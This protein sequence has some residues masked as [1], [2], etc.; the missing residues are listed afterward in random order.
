VALVHTVVL[1]L[2][3]YLLAW[4]LDWTRWWVS[5]IGGFVVGGLPYAVLALPW[6]AQP[7]PDL[8]AA[9]VIA[10]FSWLF[11][12]GVALGLGVLGMAGGFAAWCTWRRLG[13]APSV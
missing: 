13:P 6:G 4:R 2:P 8:V 1:G 12:G 11:Y 9:H 10:P 7:P 3:A 5:L